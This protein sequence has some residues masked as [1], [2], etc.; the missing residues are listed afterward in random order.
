MIGNLTHKIIIKYILLKIFSQTWSPGSKIPSKR[1]LA[2]HFNV[3]Y[4]VIHTILHLFKE[5]GLLFSKEKI[6]YFVSRNEYTFFNYSLR[7]F[8]DPFIVKS[9]VKDN[10][11]FNN[12][13]IQKIKENS[14]F[15][16]F[17]KNNF[18]IQRKYYH[19]DTS[20]KHF[21]IA[22]F[23]FSPASLKNQLDFTD[24]ETTP[25]YVFLAKHGFLI[26]RN[27]KFWFYSQESQTYKTRCWTNL[28]FL[29]D[30]D[31]KPFAINLIYYLDNTNNKILSIREQKIF[32]NL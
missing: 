22:Y 19:D 10:F 30:F 24:M 5:N 31:N 25:L 28:E 1:S 29:Y 2:N 14:L 16:S 7:E 3:S 20:Q 13:L 15:N 9:K 26:T 23:I 8:T 27:Q 6:G 21:K 12:D 32:F 17:T 4:T 11:N 18:Y